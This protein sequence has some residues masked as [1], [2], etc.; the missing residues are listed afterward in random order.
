[1]RGRSFEAGRALV[2]GLVVVCALLLLGGVGVA[3][4]CTLTDLNCRLRESG[5]ELSRTAGGVVLPSGF[6]TEVIASDLDVPTAFDFLPDGRV[7]IA[8]KNG[9]VKIA[10]DGVVDS[11]PVLDLTNKVNVALFRG[12]IA[13]AVDPRYA[14]NRYIYVV[15]TPRRPNTTRESKDPTYAVVSRFTLTE[16]GAVDER[17]ILGAAG[18]SAGTCSRLP[19]TADCL[20]SE[21]DH[22]GADIVFGRDDTLFVTTGDGG[23]L[24]EV[25]DQAFDAQSI[26]ALGGKVLRVTRE[27]QGVASNPFFDGDPTSN[28]S[29]VWA[30]GFRN[31][32][33]LARSPSS[34]LLMVGDVGWQSAEEINS[35][36]RGANYGWP[37]Y[38]GLS[39]T[40]GYKATPQC[41]AMYR[42]P[43]AAE[44][45]TIALPNTT[46]SASVTG[47]PFVRT[48]S[49]PTEARRYYYADW[50]AGSVH[51]ALIDQTSGDLR[52]EPSIFAENAGGPV[53]LRVGRD[54]LLY[55]LALNYGELLRIAYEP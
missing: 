24:E 51:H 32:F 39:R 19:R 8:E 4:A 22:V 5:T 31:P 18:E 17:V 46:G 45:P 28:R 50:V 23:G 26:D 6:A 48:E 11:T 35:V 40:M 2:L 16:S 41:V 54:G 21:V 38:E 14:N 55:I 25:E 37:C 15:Y 3:G 36:H 27:G 43:V 53:A 49:Y 7:L 13:I 34:D 10:S 47:G 33:R 44:P 30:R 52:G 20:P 29:K 12:L 9:L 42:H 1:M